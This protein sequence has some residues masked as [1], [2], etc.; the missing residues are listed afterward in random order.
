MDGSDQTSRQYVRLRS[1]ILAGKF[2]QPAVLLETTLAASYGVSRTPIRE[3]L[4]LLVHDGLLERA[5]RGF[6]VRSGTPE[7][8]VE[9]Y[10]ARIAL[11]SEAAA[12]AATRRTDLDLARLEQVHD[13]CCSGADPDEV[14]AANFRFHEVLWDA[15]HNATISAL[16]VRLTMQLRIYDSGP[17]SNYGE[18]EVLNSEHQSILTALRERDEERARADMRRHLE[19]SR[20]QRIRMFASR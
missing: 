16:L 7:D 12:S 15:A 19:R 18:P 17:P 2:A 10:A 13:Q 20:D 1:D 6:R 14:R 4:N 9:I 5:P 11:E 8:V 3:A